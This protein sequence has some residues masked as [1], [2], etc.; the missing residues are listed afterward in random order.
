MKILVL[1]VGLI[2]AASAQTFQ[3]RDAAWAAAVQSGDVAALDKFYTNDLIYAHSTGNVDSKKQYLDRLKTGAQKYEHVTIE[4][5][6]VVE[7]GDAV[8][9]H[10]FLRMNGISNGKPFNDHVMMLHLW[11]KQEGMWRI[12]AHQTTKLPQ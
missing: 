8:V 11:V 4:K 2:A 6:R 9:T 5:T 12:A 1:A 7:Y 3:E 10:S